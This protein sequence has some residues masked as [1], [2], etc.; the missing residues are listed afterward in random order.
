MS[1]T[2]IKQ[3]VHAVQ[4]VIG[5]LTGIRSAP[6]YAPDKAPPL[7]FSVAWGSDGTFTFGAG[8][9]S[10]L[11]LHTIIVEVHFERIY[12]PKAIEFSTP[13]I[14][15]V[16]TALMQTLISATK[17]SDFPQTFE[18]ITYTYGSMVWGQGTGAVN[19]FGIRFYIHGVKIET[20]LI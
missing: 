3:A 18:N 6:E 2:T 15:S 12:L 11:G 9:G 7:P 8:Y 10:K 20:D 13:F 14:D 4:D 19:T 17:P 16:S 5:A 1:A